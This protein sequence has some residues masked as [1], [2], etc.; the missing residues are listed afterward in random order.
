MPENIIYMRTGIPKIGMEI[1]VSPSLV[2]DAAIVLEI[3]NG[4]FE[5]LI[6]WLDSEMGFVGREELR[7]RFDSLFKNDTGKSKSLSRFVDAIH[8]RLRDVNQSVH[9]FVSSLIE[10]L[11]EKDSERKYVPGESMESFKDRITKLLGKYECYARQAKAEE[12]S[13]RIGNPLEQFELIC[14]I[15]PVF[16]SERES[17][18]GMVP[19]TWLKVVTTQSNG[20]PHSTE[21]ILSEDDLNTIDESLQKA[22]QKIKELKRAVIEDF[23]KQIPATVLTR[24]GRESDE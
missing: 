12:L 9:S 6:S 10:W 5:S 19:L 21:V 4:E 17:I 16:N 20:M 3:E 23:G 7:V 14:D 24:T 18:E 13:Q 11:N 22:K 1:S 15:R 2:N 8:E